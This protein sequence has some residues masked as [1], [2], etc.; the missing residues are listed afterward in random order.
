MMWPYYVMVGTP[1]LVALLGNHLK[2]RELKNRLII[3]SFFLIWLLILCFRSEKV[4]I[5][6]I[7][8]H[9]MFIEASHM[10]FGRI[11]NIA[12]SGESDVAFYFI[13][14]VI[15]FFTMDFRVAMVIISVLS[16]GPIATLYILNAKQN[17][18][19]SVV[20]FLSL[21]L[22][23]IYFSALRQVLAMS[24]AVPAYYFTKNRKLVLFLLMAF[25]AFLFHHSAIVL[26]LMYPV[27]YFDLRI[28]SSLLIIIPIII[29]VYVFR[30]PI[31]S[32]LKAFL[33]DYQSG[34]I[35]ET[36]AIMVFLLLVGL[37]VLSYIIP[38]NSLLDK[39]TLGMRN[40]LLL[41][42]ILQVFAGINSLAMRMNYYYLLFIPLLIPRILN[43]ASEKNRYVANV[44]YVVML[45]FFT[46]WYIFRAYTAGDT[47]HVYPFFPAWAL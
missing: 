1:A 25:L 15:S 28:N 18:Y 37:L 31:F 39:D 35:R 8:Y 41:A 32:W 44:I 9:R 7:N 26:L 42:T 10:S 2:N 22:F 11:F 16:L 6:T 20:L 13:S 5:D 24:F 33:S 17:A 3:A 14:K 45:G 34:T 12:S 46:F 23:S 30:V 43:S 4:G 27:Y 21:G 36:G 29:I 40:L 47:L 38:D 19:L